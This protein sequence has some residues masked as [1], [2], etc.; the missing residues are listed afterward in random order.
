M[1]KKT[2]WSVDSVSVSMGL[3][4]NLGNYESARIQAEVKLVSS[5]DA[6]DELKLA[7]GDYKEAFKKA[8]E[9]VT[10]EVNKKLIRIKQAQVKSKKKSK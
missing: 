3:T 1:G 10:E 2:K 4:I 8:E 6:P 9:L 5:A 7:E